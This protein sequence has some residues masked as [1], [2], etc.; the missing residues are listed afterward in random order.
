MALS[1][2]QAGLGIANPTNTTKNNYHASVCCTEELTVSLTDQ[3]PLDTQQYIQS[4]RSTRRHLR[5]D[6]LQEAED[7]LRKIRGKVDKNTR[8]RL[9]RAQETG[10][11]LTLMP[12]HL[13][14]TAL[15]PQEFHD[16]IRMRYGLLP[17]HLPEKCDGC[18]Q[19]FSVEHAM[20]CKKGGLVVLRHNDVAQEWSELCCRALAPSAVSDEPLI[21]SGQD[22]N[23]NGANNTTT[24]PEL[25]GD[26]AAHGFW[27]RGT[28]AIF[29]I[30]ITDTD[31]PS[32][33]SQ[34]PDKVLARH[35]REKKVK[36]S[37]ACTDRRR[38][39]TPLV[40][41][42]DGMLAAEAKAA[43]KRLASR[44]VTKWK[45]P[46]SELCGFVC[47]HLSVALVRS[48]SH[49]LRGSRDPNHTNGYGY[50]GNRYGSWPL[51]L[52]QTQADNNER[53]KRTKTRSLLI[54]WTLHMTQCVL[55]SFWLRILMQ[56]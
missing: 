24:N 11:W 33:R 50:V 9:Q 4:V 45:R 55:W 42:T 12:N 31:A 53:Y 54:I 41:S 5:D 21:Y 51:S 16:S 14:G 47:S 19:K 8:R 10:H 2:R 29:D 23:G 36:Y 6:R 52:K 28:T 1:T 35:E 34:D 27:T 20:T 38:H 46:Y 44:L 7:I 25:R 30:R 26:V 37:K 17:H 15:S 13:N 48:A 49:C 32:Y 39:F 22:S 43:S 3:Q 18:R 56:M 40:F